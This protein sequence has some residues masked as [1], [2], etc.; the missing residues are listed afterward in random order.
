MFSRVKR[1]AMLSM[2]AGAVLCAVGCD[3]TAEADKNLSSALSQSNVTRDPADA[4]FAGAIISLQD[5]TRDNV[6]PGIKAQAKAKVASMERQQADEMLRESA[7]KDIAAARI[8]MQ[9][10]QAASQVQA[11]NLQI[12]RYKGYKGGHYWLLRTSQS[13]VTPFPIRGQTTPQPRRRTIHAHQ[14]C[15]GSTRSI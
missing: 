5:A 3:Q 10:L 9:V 8:A 12:D 11:T 15:R 1:I 4:Q 6:S 13:V 2:A 14:S 7:R